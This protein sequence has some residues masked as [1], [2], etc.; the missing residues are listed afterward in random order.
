MNMHKYFV[1]SYTIFD[2]NAQLRQNYSQWI[3]R[4]KQSL[5]QPLDDES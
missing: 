5:L 4:A 1:V 2:S 3:N